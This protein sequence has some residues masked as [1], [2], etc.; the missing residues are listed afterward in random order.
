[1]GTM[2]IRHVDDQLKQRL[3]ARAAA[4]GRSMADEVR[5][6]LRLALAAGENQSK[7]PAR[8]DHADLRRQ[9]AALMTSSAVIIRAERDER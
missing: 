6:I 8:P 2:T 1:M 5:D 7:R 9:M 3:R 4:H